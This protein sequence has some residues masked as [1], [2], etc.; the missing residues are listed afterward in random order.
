M[1]TT[2][3]YPLQRGRNL[4]LASLLALAALAWGILIWQAAAPADE[5]RGLTLGLGPV[6]FSAT[7]VT[8]MVAMMFPTAAPMMLTFARVYSH[9]RQRGQAFVPTWVFAAGYLLIWALF[10]VAAYV[11]ARTAEA[12]AAPSAPAMELGARVGGGVI[13]LAGLYQ[14]SPLKRLCLT[15]C[16]SPLS[17][18]LTAWRDGYAGAFRMGLEHGAYC[19]GCC[20]LL[21]VMLFPLGLMNVAVMAAVT[22]LIFAEKS[23]PMGERVSRLA[24]LA[25]IAYGLLVVLV[26]SLLPTA[27]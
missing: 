24:A 15:K 1:A 12:I 2:A 13:A 18:I 3:S 7:W 27:M 9:K 14:L 10:G 11:L 16:R 6:L 22:L 21:F 20:W 19:L 26:P 4:I 17:F 23:L 25:L 8:M 5:M